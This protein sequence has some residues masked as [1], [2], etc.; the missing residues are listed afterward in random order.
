MNMQK[1]SRLVCLILCLT[2][3]YASAG[4]FDYILPWRWN[5][6]GTPITKS[7]SF[8]KN[9][10]TLSEKNNKKNQPNAP[11]ISLTSPSDSTG[12]WPF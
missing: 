12:W 4:I 11:Q 1:I 8:T 5:L 7:T 6:F 2:Y 10:D 3:A 9:P